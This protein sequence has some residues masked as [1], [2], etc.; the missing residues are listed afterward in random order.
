MELARTIKNSI[1]N[2]GRRK[3]INDVSTAVGFELKEHLCP[4]MVYV[5]MGFWHH[6]ARKLSQPFDNPDEL[7]RSLEDARYLS[8]DTLLVYDKPADR[9]YLAQKR[10]HYKETG[11]CMT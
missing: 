3:K 10:Q 7:K 4:Q 5:A 2:I 9:Y 8:I 1:K 11:Q 6:E